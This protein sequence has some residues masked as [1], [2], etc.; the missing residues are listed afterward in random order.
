MARW[1]EVAQSLREAIAAGQ[2][3]PGTKIPREAELETMFDTSRTTVRRAVA[4]LTT[5]GLVSPVRRGGTTVRIQPER[6]TVP[7]DAGVYR[8]E[9]GYFFGRAVQE[10]RAVE[11]PTV[12]EGLCPPEVAPLLG[13]DAGDAVIV[14]SRVMGDPGT[15][16]VRQLATSFLPADLAAGTVLAA[17][18]TGVG[19]IYDRMENELGWGRLDWEGI[20]SA[21]AATVEE[22]DLLGLAAGMPVLCVTRTAIATAGAA[23]GRVVEANITCRDASLYEIRYPLLRQE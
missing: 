10:L 20:I 6:S 5:E 22:R 11:P 3:P 12:Q 15:G 1:H 19:G 23:E 21:R 8:D 14:R 17:A 2:Y 18:D 9:L 16:R 4:Q 7:L 13:L